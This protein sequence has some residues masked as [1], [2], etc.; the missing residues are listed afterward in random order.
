MWGLKTRRHREPA[1]A[2]P[3]AASTSLLDER[4]LAEQLGA[5]S[6]EASAW[7][8]CPVEERARLHAVHA[9]GSRTCWTCSTTTKGDS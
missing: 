1:P 2:A 4:V 6:L 7:A 3:P 8:I 9:D 5:G